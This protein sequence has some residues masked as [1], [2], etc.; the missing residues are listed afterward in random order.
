MTPGCSDSPPRVSAADLVVDFLLTTFETEVR[1]SERESVDTRTRE[2]LD[3]GCCGPTADALWRGIAREAANGGTRTSSSVG[4][5]TDGGAHGDGGE[6]TDGAA[7]G[8]CPKTSREDLPNSSSE[9]N[10]GFSKA[11]ATDKELMKKINAIDSCCRTKAVE[12]V[13]TE[14]TRDSEHYTFWTLALFGVDHVFH[15]LVFPQASAWMLVQSW[16]GRMR[17]GQW[18]APPNSRP[19]RGVHQNQE[20]VLALSPAE[21]LSP[22]F[23]AWHRSMGGGK[24]FASGGAFFAAL[25]ERWP[26]VEGDDGRGKLLGALWSRPRAAA[27][28]KGARLSAIGYLRVPREH[29]IHRSGY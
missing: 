20:G 18:L 11:R 21:T 13:I 12:E 29:I 5:E 2:L 4:E 24:L 25:G 23:E 8:I 10:S 19:S 27:F 15:V 6:E 16:G 3:L 7:H 9:S 14:R 26:R 22:P 28:D 1:R 17:L